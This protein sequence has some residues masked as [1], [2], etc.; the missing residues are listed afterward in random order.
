MTVAASRPSTG[1]LDDAAAERLAR[2]LT[3]PPLSAEQIQKVVTESEGDLDPALRRETQ[4]NF[5]P[6]FRPLDRWSG[7]QRRAAA[8]TELELSRFA[9][10]VAS[11]GG[12]LVIMYVPNP[13]Q[14]GPRE[15]AIGRLFDRVDVGTVLPPESGIQTWLREV[16][17]RHS[18]ELIDPSE[19]MRT[20]D[21]SRPAADA[22]PL[23]LRADCHFAARGHQ[24]LA[25]YLAD[26]LLQARPA[27]S[28]RG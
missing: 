18:I 20:F 16:T 2:S 9:E 27:G 28:P 12:R 1:A 10:D 11:D 23:Y 8:A 15:C 5:W 19:A 6:S 25:D 17:A 22:A 26:W 14:I 24:F 21:R 7:A 3:E 4:R 13:L